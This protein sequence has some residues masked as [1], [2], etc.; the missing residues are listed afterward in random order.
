M[1]RSLPLLLLCAAATAAGAWLSFPLPG[2]ETPVSLQTVVVCFAGLVLGPARAMA[3]MAIYLALGAA[4]LPVF[5]NGASGLDTLQ[6]PTAGYLAGFIAAQPVIALAMFL[7]SDDQRIVRNLFAAVCGHA[8]IL[9]LGVLWMQHFQVWSWYKTL[10]AGLWPFLPGAAV[11]S[12]VAA[13]AA[14]WVESTRS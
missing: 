1:R 2:L 4:G 7:F 5:A 8:V 14:A 9:A 10:E 12:V 6:G 13:L 11:K 3:A